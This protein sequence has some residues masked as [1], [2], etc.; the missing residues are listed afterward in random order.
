MKITNVSIKRIEN[1]KCKGFASVILDD[2]IAVHN[3][4]IIEGDKGLFIAMPSRKGE[5]GKYY[6]YVHPI[7]NDFRKEL[8]QA[9]IEE[10]KK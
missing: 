1:D 9:I 10:F 8:E 3:M 5:D 7:T 2:I 4:R 6:D